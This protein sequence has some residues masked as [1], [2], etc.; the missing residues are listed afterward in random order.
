MAG[1]L[2]VAKV[3]FELADGS[4]IQDTWGSHITSHELDWACVKVE[5]GFGSPV[6]VVRVEA[7][8]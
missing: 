4:I 5:R 2:T 7:E 8:E 1:T 3:T 6:A